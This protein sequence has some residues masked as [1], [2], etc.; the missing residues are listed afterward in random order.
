[1]CAHSKTRHQILFLIAS[2]TFSLGSHSFDVMADDQNHLIAP[3]QPLSPEQQRQ[4]FQLPEGFEIQLIAAEPD[5]GQPMNLNFDAAGRL[6]VTSSLE[7]PY[8]VQAEGVQDRPGNFPGVG[9]PPAK[10]RV[11]I[12]DGIEPSG[13]SQRII[14]FVVTLNIPIG[15]LPLSKAEALVYSIPNIKKLTDR[16]HDG[17]SDLSEELIGPF[18][19]IDTHGM[20]NSFTYGLDGWVYACHG[21]ANQ[22]NVEAT[23]GSKLQLNSGN[24]YRFRPDGSQ[25]QQWTWGQVNPFGLTFDPW[26]N[27]YSADCHSHPL[28]LLLPGAYYQ[29]FGKPHDGLGYG[30]DMIDH[31][32][33]STGICG[34]AWY[35]AE[36]YPKEFRDCMYLCNPVTG[37]IHRDQLRWSGSSP[38]VESQPDFVSCDDPW[39]RPVDIKLGPDGALYVADFYNSIIGH[40]EVPLNHPS[41][42]RNRGRIWRIVYTG[43]QQDVPPITDL[44]LLSDS[45]LIEELSSSNITTRTLATH[46][47]VGRGQKVIPK[48]DDRIRQSDISANEKIHATWVMERLGLL[49]TQNILSL[50]HTTNALVRVHL[51]R[52]LGNR[53]QWSDDDIKIISKLLKDDDAMVQRAAVE[54]VSMHADEERSKSLVETVL[55]LLENT[56]V[57]DTHLKHSSRIALRN[58]LQSHE[59]VWQSEFIVNRSNSSALISVALATHTESAAK[60]LSEA[61]ESA[62]SNS[63]AL[64]IGQYGSIFIN[65]QFTVRLSKLAKRN[66][67][68]FTNLLLS[69][70]QGLVSSKKSTEIIEQ[71]ALSHLDE[72]FT[73]AEM[74]AADVEAVVNLITGLK[75]KSQLPR[76][77]E[78]VVN[79]AAGYKFAAGGLAEFDDDPLLNALTPLLQE[80]DIPQLLSDQIVEVILN[81]ALGPRKE[82]VI[83]A[84]V[85]LPSNRQL[86]VAEKLAESREGTV[87]LF[88]LVE[89][90]KA[91]PRLLTRPNVKQRI[92]AHKQSEY[93]ELI[94]KLTQGLP[95][96]NEQAI[97]LIEQRLRQL[98]KTQSSTAVGFEVFK[99]NCAN[100]HRVGQEGNLIGPQLDGIGVRP[101]VRI[102][103]DILA[104][105]QNID[106][107]FRVT[108]FVMTDGRVQSGLI[109]RQEGSD[110]IIADQKGKEIRIPEFDIELKKTAP[111]SLM[112]ANFD[113]VLSLDDFNHLLTYLR[114]QKASK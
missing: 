59:A 75:L 27:L 2:L 85:L 26:G 100:C 73:Q 11:T 31:S 56:A 49:S 19:N 44:T 99:K 28:T 53:E 54:A 97:K 113:E 13:H 51:A 8:P 10:D 16:N 65:N 110:I 34:P 1:M 82:V 33:G 61:E 102:L 86:Q 91:S 21:F 71:V 74:Q 57:E 47:L 43:N 64:T 89:Q 5:I 60:Y 7:Y 83:S 18:G 96:E 111:L 105:N 14:Q 90:G 114:E 107:T 25:L 12:I 9:V 106:A 84:M 76:L 32:H 3:T 35:Q 92:E 37:R 52:I 45:D 109:R 38:W 50:S 30:P 15:I 29:S 68:E 103:E 77:R 4:L 69:Q 42:D 6:W 23:D 36:T 70:F 20:T 95:T 40:Y 93:Q 48:L 80:A 67:H 46:E 101:V 58:L 62:L 112:P 108:T 41:R 39:F 88:M 94:T 24:S 104:P 98:E 81:D 63:V 72:T 22:S 87:L 17:K 79:H 55:F 66:P 78:V